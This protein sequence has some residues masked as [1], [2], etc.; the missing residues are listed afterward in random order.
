MLR[1]AR[2][3]IAISLAGAIALVALQ[4][5]GVPA[6]AQQTPSLDDYVAAEAPPEFDTP[7]QAVEAFKTAVNNSDFDAVARLF[8]LDPAKAKASPGAMDTFADIQA[9]VKEKVDVED[10]DGD[11]VLDIGKI[12]WPLPFPIAKDDKGKWA[13]DTRAGLEE[14]ADRHV[15]ENELSTIDTLKAYVDA[16]EDY[17]SQDRDGDGVLE[18]AQKVVSS[19][20][21]QDGLYWPAEEFG[22]QESPAG[23]AL[24]DGD[25]LQRAKAGQGYHG[26]RY[27]ILTGQGDNIAGGKFSYIINGNMI[28]GHA[29][30][31]WPVAYGLTGVKTFLVNKNGIIYE[32]DLGANT[33]EIAAKIRTFNPSDEW[34][35]VQD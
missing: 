9:G 22:G 10:K 20:G 15:G 19:P 3:R 31:A 24:A 4:L 21:K 32:A 18:Y 16:Q 35:V 14:I 30:I 26:Y 23:P 12:Q 34:D 6:A 33:A 28:A 13:F 2:D 8:G 27:R 11:K 7:E 1:I 17:A 25:A 29:A 5:A